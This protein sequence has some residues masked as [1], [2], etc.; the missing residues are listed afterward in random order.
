MVR[1]AD[2]VVVMCWSRRQA[3]RALAR[4]AELLAAPMRSA[5]TELTG[6]NTP[7]NPRREVTPNPAA[8]GNRRP[9]SAPEGGASP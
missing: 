6:A 7:D 8:R 3:E 2:D 5:G 9:L 1:F 4:L